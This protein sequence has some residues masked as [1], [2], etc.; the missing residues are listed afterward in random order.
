MIKQLLLVSLAVASI[1]SCLLSD[2]TMCG[3][4]LV[5]ICVYCRESYFDTTSTSC[6]TP[7]TVIANC[8]NY[9]SATECNGCAAGYYLKANACVALTLTNCYAGNDQGVCNTCKNSKRYDSTKNECTDVACTTANCANCMVNGTTEVCVAC[10]AAFKLSIS[11]TSI[12]C[13][14]TTDNCS[15]E[16]P[17]TKTCILCHDGYYMKNTTCMSSSVQKLGFLMFFAFLLM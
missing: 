3:S 17:L 13:T 4:C 7:A 16:N 2:D 1:T 9:K 8:A 5:G 15:A 12:T 10:N 6:K 14:A 11:G